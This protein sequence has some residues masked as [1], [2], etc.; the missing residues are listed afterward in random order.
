MTLARAPES[1]DGIL[2]LAL[3]ACEET[4]NAGMADVLEPL[5]IIDVGIEFKTDPVVALAVE[6]D[7]GV[8]EVEILNRGAVSR[9][10]G[11]VGVVTRAD[12]CAPV[13]GPVR[14]PRETTAIA[15]FATAVGFDRV[16]SF[17]V[18]VFCL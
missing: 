9:V 14:S 2:V 17:G 5:G 6:V 7:A 13:N 3:N 8:V 12:T 4:S 11:I 1:L 16:A 18:A 10:A 15:F